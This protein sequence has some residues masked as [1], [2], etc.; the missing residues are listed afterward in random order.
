MKKLAASAVNEYKFSFGTFLY[1]VENGNETSVHLYDFS[2]FLCS[3]KHKLMRQNSML[4]VNEPTKNRKS[5]HMGR[6][7]ES[8]MSRCCARK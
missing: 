1:F 7:I 4:V 8:T 6:A 3:V 5:F 2:Y